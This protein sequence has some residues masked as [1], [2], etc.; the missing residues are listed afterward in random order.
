[1]RFINPHQHMCPNCQRKYFSYYKI[2]QSRNSVL[3][4]DGRCMENTMGRKSFNVFKCPNCKVI[5]LLNKN[6]T[7]EGGVRRI[8]Q[9]GIDEK[10]INDIHEPSTIAASNSVK[11][12]YVKEEYE[13]TW[14]TSLSISE[15]IDFIN[16]NLAED[17]LEELDNR[18]EVWREYNHRLIRKI[19]IKTNDEYYVYNRLSN[20]VN[21]SYVEVFSQN[22]KLLNNMKNLFESANEEDFWELNLRRILTLINTDNSNDRL[23]AAEIYRNLGDFEKCRQLLMKPIVEPYYSWMVPLM[24]EQCELLNRCVVELK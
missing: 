10:R 18:V 2:N 12:L 6:I 11:S 14:A 20:E 22:M 16:M 9:R 24:L 5:F 15:Y 4:S 23:I 3:L 17:E 13:I 1:M 19:Q 8:K 7:K 21:P